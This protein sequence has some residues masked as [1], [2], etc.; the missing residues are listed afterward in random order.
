MDWSVRVMAPMTNV[1]VAVTVVDVT[2]LLA[3]MA[4]KVAQAGAVVAA[5]VVAARTL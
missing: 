3:A 4:V 5:L 2:H 1:L